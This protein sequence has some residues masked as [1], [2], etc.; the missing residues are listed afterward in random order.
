MNCF[1]LCADFMS[2]QILFCV[3]TSTVEAIIAFWSE[4]HHNLSRAFKYPDI[5]TKYFSEMWKNNGSNNKMVNILGRPD[6]L[7]FPP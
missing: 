1:H 3:I 6:V 4:F 7:W 5:K 2:F